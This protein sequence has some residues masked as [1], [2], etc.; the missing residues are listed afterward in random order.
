MNRPQF[1]AELNQ[2][3]TFFTPDERTA[4]M[5]SYAQKFDDAGEEGEAALIAELRTPM[6]VAIDLKRRQE[7]GDDFSDIFGAAGR[8]P[9]YSVETE[10]PESLT[11][12]DPAAEAGELRPETPEDAASGTADIS[13]DGDKTAQK[14]ASAEDAREIPA[15]PAA[16]PVPPAAK[17]SAGRVFGGVLLSILIIAVA[18]C[19]AA[20]GALCLTAAGY[21]IM[22]GL[23]TIL[24]LTDALFLFAGGLVLGGVGLLI[25]WF[26]IWAAICLIR[27]L[28]CVPENGRVRSAAGAD[29]AKGVSSSLNE[30][31]DKERDTK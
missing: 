27:K 24:V 31:A 30:A 12:K 16:Q 4:I 13:A 7:A 20:V 1:L 10:T 14:E 5:A 23:K 9:D 2:Y 28:F 29:C 11:D 18:V 26:A 15:K 19:I 21:F 8:A 25:V 6:R 3:L 17:L 22:A